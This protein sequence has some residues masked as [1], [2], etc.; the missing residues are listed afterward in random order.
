M[1]V[2]GLI[3]DLG[4][5]LFIFGSEGQ[6]DVV[7]VSGSLVPKSG[8]GAHPYINNL[9]YIRRWMCLFG[10]EHLSRYLCR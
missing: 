6:W 9:G 3:H 1:Q 7:G 2:T 4:K 8:L 5:L 10:Q